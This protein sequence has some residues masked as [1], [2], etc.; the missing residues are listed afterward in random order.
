[1]RK[2]TIKSIGMIT[3]IIFIGMIILGGSLI[4]WVNLINNPIEPI[5]PDDPIDPY[6]K[7]WE[8]HELHLYFN[9]YY[10][11]NYTIPQ[12][13]KYY[14]LCFDFE[15]G[16]LRSDW[17]PPLYAVSSEMFE[18][19]SIALED[20]YFDHYE[21]PILEKVFVFERQRYCCDDYSFTSPYNDTWYI[22]V[23]NSPCGTNYFIYADMIHH[24]EAS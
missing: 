22:F 10:L 4:V 14:N 16:C 13:Y 7:S 17:Y 18:E 5:E 24:P 11:L 1:M 12:N 9:D 19:F 2:T 6:I 8:E 20:E 3:V 15:Y 23:C 21:D